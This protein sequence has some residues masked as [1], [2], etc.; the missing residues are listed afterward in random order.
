VPQEFGE[1]RKEAGKNCGIKKK[2]TKIH[3]QP[4]FLK[5]NN[6]WKF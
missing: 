2:I 6:D 5:N 1:G 3:E 4:Y